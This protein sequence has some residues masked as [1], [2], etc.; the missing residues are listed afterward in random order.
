MNCLNCSSNKIAKLPTQNGD[1]F[2]LT[3]VD[4]KTSNV[5]PTSGFLVDAFGCTNCG[6]I[7]LANEQL[8]NQEI[9]FEQ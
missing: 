6:S 9:I 8:L 5:F 3:E 7:F 2:L 1:K 4:S